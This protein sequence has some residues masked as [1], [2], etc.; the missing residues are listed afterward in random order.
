MPRTGLTLGCVLGLT[1]TLWSCGDAQDSPT[2]IG[3][4]LGDSPQ[5]APLVIQDSDPGILADPASYQ[6]TEIPGVASVRRTE[7]AA[8]PSD[9]GAAPS[10]NVDD[11]VRGVVEF[12][13]NALRDADPKLA[14][15]AFDAEQVAMLVEDD[16]AMDVL[17]A[18][19]GTLNDSLRFEIEDR[20]GMTKAARMLGPLGGDPDAAPSWEILDADHASVTPNVARYLL[21]PTVGD[22][23]AIALARQADGEWK[24]QLDQPLD[25]DRVNTILEF[26][27]RVQDELNKI[28]D[29]VFDAEELDEDL[30]ATAI[31]RALVGEPVELPA[32]DGSGDDEP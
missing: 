16:D 6:P 9:T 11:Q 3:N 20:L 29:W 1:L 5:E 15:R 4:I 17:Y 13:L 26:H 7:E 8:G 28:V 23:S 12:F 19:F 22:A 30:L 2:T 27:E 18:T 31:N 21:G 24:F 10:A 32:T 14:L 25:A